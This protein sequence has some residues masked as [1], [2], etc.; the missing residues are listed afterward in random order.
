[1]TKK[2]FKSLSTII[3]LAVLLAS[4]TNAQSVLRFTS[5]N[6]TDEKAIQLHWASTNSEIYQIQYANALGT[7]D[8]G[9]TAW[10]ILYDGYPSQGTNTLWLDTGNYNLVPQ[11]LHPKDMPMRFYRI[12]DLGADTASDEPSVSILSPTNGAVVFGELTITVIASTDQPV[13]S[14][15]KLYVDGQEMQMADSKTN[16]TDGSGVTNYEADTYSINTCEWGNGTH[17]LFATTECSSQSQGANNGSQSLIGHAASTFVPVT[18]NNLVTR[19][20]FSQP[21]FD[22]SS[23]QTQQVSAVFP[24]NSDWTLNIVDAYSNVVQTATGS[25]NSMLYNWDGTANGTSLPNGIYYYYITAATNGLANALA[26]G[27]SGGGSGGSPPSPSFARSSV[28]GSDSS[29]LW[30]VAPD[31]EN[32]VPFALYPPGFDTNGFTIFSA[33]P[34]EV[35]TLTASSRSES[36]IAMDSGGASPAGIGDPGYITPLPDPQPAPPSPQRPPNNPIKGFAGTVGIGYQRYLSWTNGNTPTAPLNGVLTQHVQLQNGSAVTYHDMSSYQSEANNFI[37][38]ANHYGLNTTLN[39]TDDQLNINDLRGSG[40]P[41]NNVNLGVLM[42]HGTYG[43][44]LDYTAG[45]CY[46]MYFPIAAGGSATYLRMSE[47]N[48]GGAGTNGLKWMAIMACFSLYHTDWSSMQ[49]RGTYPYNSNLHLLLGCDTTEYTNPNLMAY[50]AKYMAFGTSTNY[51]PMTI[52]AAW[53][54]AAQ[55]AYK[56]SGINYG[57]TMKFTVAGDTACSDDMLQTNYVPTG[58]WFYDS[59]V[60]VW[61]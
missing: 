18:F 44:G 22:P 40:T 55:D 36:I 31:S 6:A 48:L 8:D 12:V 60:Q 47:M 53:Y 61:P 45:I 46:Q 17:T 1:M 9:S 43:T 16:Y 51:N 58:V 10:Q 11:V 21:S 59:P 20:A 54:Q 4:S 28:A 15:T 23:G 50:W 30:A 29:E 3:A 19:I 27:G 41:F 26:I 33:T 38:A 35:Q 56:Q 7:N 25:G 32:V 42:L 13:L 57:A 34:S 5:V 14:G 39:K 52:R 2:L 37:T 24:L 49:S